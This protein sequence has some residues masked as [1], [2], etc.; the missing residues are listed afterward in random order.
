MKKIIF[1]IVAILVL[2]S[3]EDSS[4]DIELDIIGLWKKT[5]ETKEYQNGTIEELILTDCDLEQTIE[6]QSNEEVI[7]TSY[8]GDDCEIP[9]VLKGDYSY[10]VELQEL[11]LPDNNKQIVEVNGD[12]MSFKFTVRGVENYN[13]IVYFKRLE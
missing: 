12:T 4:N 13:K 2:S 3:C 11:T 1:T 9:S 7:L 8:L 10:D 5:A 6:L